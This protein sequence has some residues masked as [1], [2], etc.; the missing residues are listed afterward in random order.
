MVGRTMYVVPYV[1]GPL[2]SPYSK[3]GVELTDSIYVVLNTALMTRMGTVALDHLD[4]QIRPGEVF[5]LLGPNGSGKST[6]LKLLLG[7]I[8]PSGGEARAGSAR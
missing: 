1:M 8:V 5:G 7:L 3:V 4:L 2:G 6:T